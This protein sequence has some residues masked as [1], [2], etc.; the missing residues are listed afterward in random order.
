[1]EKQTITT[2]DVGTVDLAPRKETRAERLAR[3][4]TKALPGDAAR[5]ASGQ[6]GQGGP[7]YEFH[8]LPGGGQ[9]LL[10]ENRETGERLGVVGTTRDELLDALEARLA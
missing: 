2:A 8:T 10:V 3:L 9:R 4:L 7:P 6:W 1:M 5:I